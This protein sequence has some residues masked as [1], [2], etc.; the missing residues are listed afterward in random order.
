M[1]AIL[2]IVILPLLFILRKSFI[3]ESEKA[4]LAEFNC[5]LKDDGTIGECYATV[6]YQVAFLGTL[7]YTVWCDALDKWL[8]VTKL[9]QLDWKYRWSIV[10]NMFF[11]ESYFGSLVLCLWFAFELTLL[12]VQMQTISRNL[13]LWNIISL[14]FGFGAQ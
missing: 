11:V 1:R 14:E 3:T 8:W 12:K 10:C 2:G 9:F 4:A 6:Y 13:H 5:K 7:G